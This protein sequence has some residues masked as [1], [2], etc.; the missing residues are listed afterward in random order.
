M[1]RG[2]AEVVLCALLA[3][4]SQKRTGGAA[5][6]FDDCFVGS[7]A[8]SVRVQ[9]RCTDLDGL[10]VAVLRAEGGR[11]AADPV[12]FIPGGPGQSG[13]AAFA[14]VAGAFAPV[15]RH[16]DIVIIEPRGVGESQ[17]LTCSTPLPDD[18]RAPD[19]LS[20]LRT[21]AVELRDRPSF[22]N[23]TAAVRDIEMVRG[24]LGYQTINLY[25][26]SYGTRVA[27]Q[28]AKAR[29]DF[30]RAL[31]LDGVIAPE[32]SLGVEQA[33]ATQRAFDA[34]AKRAGGFRPKLA[35]DGTRV[36]VRHP[37]TGEPTHV[38]LDDRL[39]QDTLRMMLYQS[40]LTALIPR[41]LAEAGRGNLVPLATQAA[42]AR[43]SVEGAVNP[44]VYL[45]VVCAEDIPYLPPEHR[46]EGLFVS[47]VAELIEACKVW[48][49]TKADAALKQ[50]VVTDT[51]MFLLSGSADPV[52]P[53]SEAEK[54][55]AHATHA[56][57]LVLA[58]QGHIG[59]VRGCVPRLVADFI[60]DPA[61]TDFDTSCAAR[62]SALPLFDG[63]NGP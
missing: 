54:V 31:V 22:I 55:A 19:A 40:E 43:A 9:A 2:C 35:L 62:T 27:L 37:V 12:F 6:S 59:V 46:D 20:R 8:G 42:L 39:L 17:P 25:G 60:D 7:A 49:V 23:T 15:R 61:A 58:D 34:V 29:P 51:P 11:R 53:P 45:S 41:V 30:V 4:C 3:A 44:L 18:L 32:T 21:C 63:P 33:R 1:R 14:Q 47:R 10:K 36:A 48:P 16:R 38:E 28:V 13:F 57:H 5:P 52:T 56:H 50:P 26:A 24:A